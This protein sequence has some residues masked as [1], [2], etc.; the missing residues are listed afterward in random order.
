MYRFGYGVLE[1]TEGG[2]DTEKPGYE[3]R[4]ISEL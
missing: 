2:P 1:I 3:V 4:D